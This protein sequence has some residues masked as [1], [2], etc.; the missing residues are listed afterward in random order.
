[1]GRRRETRGDGPLAGIGIT[2]SA[3]A[4][5]RA[6]STRFGDRNRAVGF[7]RNRQTQDAK[8][9]L[10]LHPGSRLAVTGGRRRRSR[11]AVGAG[12]VSDSGVSCNHR[13]SPLGRSRRGVR[14]WQKVELGCGGLLAVN[15]LLVNDAPVQTGE[16]DFDTVYA[17]L[18]REFMGDSESTFGVRTV[19][20]GEVVKEGGTTARAGNVSVDRSSN[21]CPSI[22]FSRWI[23]PANPPC[24]AGRAAPAG[25]P[26]PTPR[27][28]R[29]ACRLRSGPRTGRRTPPACRSGGTRGRRPRPYRGRSSGS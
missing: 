8:T 19:N 9:H 18:S 13:S 22:A 3:D 17:F 29:S 6:F 10:V 7:K 24:G 20:D 23:A 1:M 25:P 12:E 2:A 27:G 16:F 5:L 14:A 21:R 26:C 28:A 4:E 11:Y 15:V